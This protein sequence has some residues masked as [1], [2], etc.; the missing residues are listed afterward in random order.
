M[1]EELVGAELFVGR[2][3][4]QRVGCRASW[5]LV[6]LIWNELTVDRIHYT[7]CYVR[8]TTYTYVTDGK[9]ISTTRSFHIDTNLLSTIVA[10]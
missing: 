10:G 3:G 2:F 8:H 6:D 9:A 5:P 4:L 7:R 1:W